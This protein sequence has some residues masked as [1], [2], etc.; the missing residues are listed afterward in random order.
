MCKYAVKK[1]PFVIT[2]VAEQYK[3][4]KMCRKAIL[5][6][7]EAVESVPDCY[8]INKYVIDLLIFSIMH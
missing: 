6:N 7:D 8:K 3:I 2:Y 4:Q 5:E 1:F